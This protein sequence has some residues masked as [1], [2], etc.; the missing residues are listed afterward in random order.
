MSLVQLV[1]MIH[2]NTNRR[3]W[4][5]EEQPDMDTH[6]IIFE[7]ADELFLN[8]GF[9]TNRVCIVLHLPLA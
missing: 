3:H 1:L 2:M 8:I 6:R 7:S 9:I 4:R 5:P